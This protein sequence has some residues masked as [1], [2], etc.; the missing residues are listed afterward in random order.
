MKN[1]EVA[2][3]LYEMADILDILGVQWKPN[4]YRRAARTIET[5]SD[6]IEDIYQKGGVKGLM[7]VP[8]VGENIAKKIEEYLRTGKI[9]ELQQLEKKIP[10]GV[11]EMMHLQGLGPKKAWRLYKELRIKNLNDLKKAIKAQKV[12]KLAGFGEKSESDILQSLGMHEVGEKRKLLLTGL[13]VARELE[14]RLRALPWVKKAEVAGSVR[15]RKETIADIDIL[16]IS[17]EADKVMKYFTSMADVRRILAKGETK[18]AVVLT[19][20]LQAD[21]RVLDD[22]SFG[23]A[24]QYFTGSKDH[25]VKL[26][27]I[28]IKKGFK[29]SEYGLFKRK[30]EAYVAGRTEE[31][32]YRKLGLPYIEPELRENTGE[33]EAAMKRKLPALIGY[34][35]I[36]GDCHTHTTWSDGA[37]TTEEMVQAAIKRGYEYIAI[38]DHSKSTIIANGLDDKRLLKHLDEIERLQRRYRDITILKGSECD[39]LKSGELDYRP[40]IL[41]KLDVV[42]AS[43][44]ASF[45]MGKEDMTKR[46]LKA[47]TSGHVTAIG[48]PTARLI[49]TRPGFEFDLEKVAQACKDAG[50]AFEINGN[51][52]RLDLRD[53]HIKAANELGASFLIN[54]DSH[55][56]NHLRFIELGV[57][58]ARRGWVSARSVL[59]SQSASRFLKSLR[60]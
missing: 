14:T 29:L 56:E 10:K 6:A 51:P 36:R 17:K 23:A 60:R 9:K 19:N 58:Q 3:I 32:V 8:G 47:I 26:R 2:G 24:M 13:D 38:T 25:N 43:V 42:V 22:K 34:D 48:H 44:H 1:Q 35:D 15:R 11:D 4:A 37:N 57:A 52:S 5:Y 41:K 21:V 45:K 28:A 53:S 7:D 54:T 49:N 16:V 55:S 27:G 20:G 46:Y 40:E 39:I 33:I 59:N 31:D 18:S 30:G 12:R 50:V